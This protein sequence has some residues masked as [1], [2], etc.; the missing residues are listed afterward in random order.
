[1][2][3]RGHHDAGPSHGTRTGRRGRLVRT[4]LIVGVPLVILAVTVGSYGWYARALAPLDR[5]DMNRVRVVVTKGELSPDIARKLA[6]ARI[7]RSATAFEIY[8][9]TS[10]NEDKL[11]AGTY[12]FA[13]SQSVSEIVGRLASGK[14]DEFSVTVLPGQTLMDVRTTLKGH[15]YGDAEIT[16]ALNGTYPDAPLATRP[17]GSSLEGFVYPDTYNVLSDEPL[18]A[19]FGRIFAHFD[20]RTSGLAPGFAAHGLSFYQGLTLASIVQREVPGSEDQRKV[21]SVFLNRLDAGME[22]GSDVTYIYG[23]S[24]LGVEPTPSLVSPYNLRDPN[25]KGLTPTPISN[26]GQSALEAVADPAQTDYLYFVSGDDD[27][28]YFSKTIA[29]HEQNVAAHCKKKCGL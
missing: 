22:L 12:A 15:G 29:E 25:N 27:V 1:M 5:A 28:T 8:A 23:A 17:A 16:A 3:K 24:L 2:R 14:T 10:G 9:R 26:P 11:Q 6:D 13:P 21:A 18:S 4:S 20:A 7:I 19:L